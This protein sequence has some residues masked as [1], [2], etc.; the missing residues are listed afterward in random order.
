MTCRWNDLSM[1]RPVDEMTLSMKWPCRW[2]D[3]SMKR[4]C[5]WNDPV[6]ETTCRQN[7]LSMK[8]PCRWN[9]LSMKRPKSMISTCRWN[10]PNPWYLPVEEMTLS[11]K[12]TTF[13]ILY[14]RYIWQINN[15]TRNKTHNAPCLRLTISRQHEEVFEMH[16]ARKRSKGCEANLT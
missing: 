12:S 14:R 2:N 7:D 16:L 11:K 10:D 9:E 6:D 1:K 3:L 5:R 13:I 4:P 8:R 15:A